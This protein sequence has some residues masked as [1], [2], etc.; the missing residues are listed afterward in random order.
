MTTFRNSKGKKV[1]L[2]DI[3]TLSRSGDYFLEET[4]TSLLVRDNKTGKLIEE[5]KK[6][7]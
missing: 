5:F 7:K 3:I 2:Q 4:P 1:A 6:E